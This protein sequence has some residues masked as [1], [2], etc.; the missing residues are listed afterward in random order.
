M[1][2]RE[3]VLDMRFT[4]DTGFRWRSREVSRIEGLSDAVF[5]FAVTLLVVSLEVPR[6]FVELRTSM[7][8]VLA[9][10]ASFAILVGIWH[11]QYIYFRRYGL[12]TRTTFVLNVILLFVVL[13]YVYPL[14][15][16]FSTLITF[17]TGGPYQVEVE[18]ALVPIIRRGDWPY[19]MTVYGLGWTTI[20][21]IFAGLYLH[22]F[23]LR[24]VLELT[25][26]EAFETRSSVRGHVIMASFGLISIAITLA[27][28]PAL[29]GWVYALIGP[30][31]GVNG[32]FVGRRKE[33]LV[34]ELRRTDA[35]A[36]TAPS[37]S[38]APST[39]SG[40]GAS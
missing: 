25:A 17:F 19:L 31:M 13:F 40:A 9:F 4:H 11:A 35:V 38:P 12:E 16:L 18:G 3:R 20:Y 10:A 26:L 32:Y 30:T 21:L 36:A 22:A 24:G 28:S 34:A 27:G 7:N 1:M 33:R 14:K 15:F 6:T 5:G 8:G 23:R 39:I 37:A 29:G 2:L